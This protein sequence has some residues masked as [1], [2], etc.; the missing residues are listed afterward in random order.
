LRRAPLTHVL[1]LTDE[2]GAALRLQAVLRAA[3]AQVGHA[4]TGGAAHVQI[5]KVR[6]DDSAAIAGLVSTAARCAVDA[7]AG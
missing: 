4:A 1:L 2:T 7:S 5:L 3:W 6:N